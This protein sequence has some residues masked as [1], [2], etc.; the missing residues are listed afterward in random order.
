MSPDTA[1]PAPSMAELPGRLQ[2]CKHVLATVA[3]DQTVLLD[4]EAGE[5]Y[6]LN[7]V[8]GRIWTLLGDRLPVAAIVEQIAAEFDAPVERIDADVREHITNVLS[9]SLVEPVAD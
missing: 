3:G 4:V 5:Y 8:G 2:P 1:S 7:R 9:M 6:T